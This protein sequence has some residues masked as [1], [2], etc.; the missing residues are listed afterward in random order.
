MLRTVLT[1]PS[2]P[3]ALEALEPYVD[4][5][6]LHLHWRYVYCNYLKTINKHN[7]DLEHGP[8]VLLEVADEAHD[9]GHMDLYNAASEAWN[10]QFYWKSMRPVDDRTG[11]PDGPLLE[12]VRGQF[13]GFAA[14]RD[15]FVTKGLEIFGGGW[16]WLCLS[17]TKIVIKTTDG[18]N[19]PGR[20]HTSQILLAC[21]LWEHAYYPTHGPDREHHLSTWFDMVANFDFA[22]AN[23]RTY[24]AR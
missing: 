18:A 11:T 5:F 13:G 8:G 14:L 17:G 10:H 24:L 20:D 4:R 22:S 1:L 2:L 16:V 3:Y 7:P 6:T 21:D 15:E 19:N 12:I 23:A 9:S